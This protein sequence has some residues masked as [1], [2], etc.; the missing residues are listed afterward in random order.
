MNSEAIL[1]R[2][3]YGKPSSDD[4]ITMRGYVMDLIRRIA[5]KEKVKNSDDSISWH[6]HREAEKI[7]NPEVLVD[8]EMI[9][10]TSKSKDERKAVY[11]VL[12]IVGK[13]SGDVR[14]TRALL[15]Y[16][17]QEQDKYVLSALLAGLEKTRKPSDVLLE[18]IFKFLS[19]ERW[20]VRHAAIQA[21]K[22]SDSPV[23]EEKL[24]ALLEST[25]DQY[26]KIYCHSTLNQ[27]GT[28]RSI[29]AISQSLTSR[30]RDVKASA[31]T[32][33]AAIATRC[34]VAT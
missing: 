21:L 17:L 12:G 1:E 8:L 20:L 5:L 9:A 31:R 2:L 14:F 13:N 11:F 10:E 6:A 15:R 4:P 18:P 16:A 7:A 28:L 24:L 3:R 27:I 33:I 26:D 23:A 25:G 22:N 32:A 29:P 19:D 30:K 34:A